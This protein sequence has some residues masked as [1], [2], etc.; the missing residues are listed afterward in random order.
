[1]KN[2]FQQWMV[3]TYSHNEMADMANHGCAGGVGGMIYYTETANLYK[4]FAEELH[5]IVA[6]YH[7]QVGQWPSYVSDE[8]GDFVRFA[9]VMVW[10]CAEWV[11]NEETR[12]EY[13]T[14]ETEETEGANND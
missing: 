7:E 6:E 10:F 13:K 14:E 1:M 4:R 12:G 3:E 9:N 11:A 8:L 2:S 5:E